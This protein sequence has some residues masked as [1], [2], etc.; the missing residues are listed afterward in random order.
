MTEIG[1]QGYSKSRVRIRSFHLR[2]IRCQI[3]GELRAVGRIRHREY[4]IHSHTIRYNRFALPRAAAFDAVS[5]GVSRCNGAQRCGNS[6]RIK[7]KINN[8]RAGTSA[9]RPPAYLNKSALL[10][11]W[12]R[13][14]LSCCFSHKRS[15]GFPPRWG[16]E[17]RGGGESGRT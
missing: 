2:N 3:S 12:P 8:T 9:R 1:W 5:P 7:F 17:R 4:R 6:G 15:R 10:S 13:R 11:R 14:W 16:G